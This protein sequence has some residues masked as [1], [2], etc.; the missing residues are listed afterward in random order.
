MSEARDGMLSWWRRAIFDFHM[1]RCRRCPSVYASL[2]ETVGALRAMRDEP[3]S[4]PK[5]TPR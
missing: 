5:K 4:E 3:V 2:E 1:R